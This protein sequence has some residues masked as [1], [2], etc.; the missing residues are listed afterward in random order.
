MAKPSAS[1]QHSVRKE[2]SRSSSIKNQEAS[3]HQRLSGYIA[4]HLSAFKLS[5]RNLSI[6]PFATAMTICAI[7]LC[8]SLPAG[9]YLFIKN[10]QQLSQ[11]WD[12]GE[13]ITLYIDSH[14]TQAQINAITDKI[15]L[16]PFVEDTTQ[17]TPEKAL[18]EFQ[19]VSGLSDML[20]LLP[21]NPL[22]GVIMIQINTKLTSESELF[23]MKETLAKMPAVK[24]AAFDYAW[25]E[26][27]NIFLSFGKMLA[28]CLYFI[29]G[30]GV[31][32]MVSNTIRLAVERHRD[33]LEVLNLIGATTAFIRRPFLYRGI[34]YG[35]LGGVVAALILNTINHTLQAPAA[36]LSSLFAGVFFLENLRFYDTV[37]LLVASAALGWIGAA[38]AFIQQRHSL[39]NEAS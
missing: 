33:E 11:G 28:K 19:S 26:K 35:G 15:K 34:L 12:K 1:Q 4:F 25:V 23:A 20:A 24:E 18:Q 39:Y 38:I 37:M 36:Q 13:A 17:L 5:F 32:L 31:I 9:L 14:A 16:Y 21:E 30:V 10:I 27:F 8:L 29:I 7:G 22:P 6:T 3:W 2:S